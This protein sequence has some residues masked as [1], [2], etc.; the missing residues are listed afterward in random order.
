[1]LNLALK[2]LFLPLSGDKNG[3]MKSMM[4]IEML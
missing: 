4:H 3:D 1:L 2:P